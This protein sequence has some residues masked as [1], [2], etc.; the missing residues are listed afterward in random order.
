MYFVSHVFHL[1]S[2]VLWFTGHLSPLFFPFY[3]GSE[4]TP[5]FDNVGA[6][7]VTVFLHRFHKCNLPDQLVLI[8]RN[9]ISEMTMK[10]AGE[11]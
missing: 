6:R 5:S 7:V 4:F 10:G 2:E 9:L 1:Q 3:A 11:D 8:K